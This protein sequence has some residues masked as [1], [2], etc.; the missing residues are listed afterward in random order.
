MT[1]TVLFDDMS[2][3]LKSFVVFRHPEEADAVTLWCVGTYLMDVWQLFPKLLINSPER[4][5]GKTTLLLAIEALVENGMIAS[6]ITPAAIYRIIEEK[7]PTLLIDEADRFLKYSE[8]LNGIINA[9]HTRRTATRIHCEKNKDGTIEQKSFS[10]WGAQVIAG[11]GGQAETLTSRSIKI[12]LRRKAVDET[13]ARMP[14]DHVE[15]SETFRDALTDWAAE[16]SDYISNMTLD[17]P[18]GASDRAQ[19]NWTPLVRVAAAIGGDWQDRA[20]KAFAK[21]EIKDKDDTASSI[22]LDLLKDIHAIMTQSAAQEMGAAEITKALISLPD[23]DWRSLQYGKPI[24]SKRLNQK[25]RE[26]QI[27]P[28]KRRDSNVYLFSDIEDNLRRY[29][30]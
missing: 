4:E 14:F 27:R 16:N 6:S 24:T 8:E 28:V 10:L 29:L 1:N 21:L 12:S 30:P 18:A 7:R 11:I 15:R 23:T 3:S 22:G 2:D 13:V 17:G 25:L 20:M 5:C 9:G 19:D 26:Y